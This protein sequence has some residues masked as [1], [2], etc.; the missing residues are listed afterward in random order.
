MD[1][2]FFER[3]DNISVYQLEMAKAKIKESSF[4]LTIKNMSAAS[5]FL[6]KGEMIGMQL[7]AT[8]NGYDFYAFGNTGAVTKDDIDRIFEPDLKVGKDK[9][10]FRNIFGCNGER[11]IYSAVIKVEDPRKRLECS[12]VRLFEKLMKSAVSK[13]VIIRFAFFGLGNNRTSRMKVL[14]SLHD[15]LSLSGKA[16]FG[17]S[18]NNLCLKEVNPDKD[19]LCDFDS[20]ETKV[21]IGECFKQFQN[22]CNSC[23]IEDE[24]LSKMPEIVDDE[25]IDTVY[26]EPLDVVDDSLFD[27]DEDWED[28]CGYDPFDDSYTEE[29]EIMSSPIK[30]S[31]YD[32]PLDE[33]GLTVRTYNCLLRAGYTKIGDIA[34]MSDKDLMKIRNLG[35]TGLTNIQTQMKNFYQNRYEEARKGSQKDYFAELNSLI[36]LSDVKKQVDK[37]TAFARMIK[38][39]RDLNLSNKVPISL[40]MDFAGNP[41]TAKTTVA[42]I[43]AGILYELGLLA[44]DEIVEVG[45]SS[46]VAKYVGQTADKVKSIFEHADGKLLFIDEAY[47]LLD[48]RENDFGDEAI[49]T[50]V[51]EMENRRSR[52]VVVFAGYPDKMKDFFDRNP[53]MRSRVPFHLEFADYDAEE[54]YRI[55]VKEAS[56]RGFTISENAKDGI[57]KICRK[58]IGNPNSGNGRFCR[59]LVESA[60]INYAYRVYGSKNIKERTFML[61]IEDFEENKLL[62]ETPKTTQFGFRGSSVEMPPA[63]HMAKA[64]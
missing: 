55:I 1:N 59:N 34:K 16:Y 42:R 3:F 13:R 48:C 41:G 62:T 31:D 50:I 14:I 49:S 53:G 26:G 15:E 38:D 4:Y 32:L 64:S 2:I 28:F 56:S 46:L 60:I 23:L 9:K 18:F 24:G 17:M 25:P 29:D 35:K 27:I 43:L 12:D 5:V 52:T 40:N 57:V 39:I 19:S 58:T 30:R 6:Q 47:S 61:E 37:I 45:R 63:Q 11:K 20:S 22:A 51:Q 8:D 7:Q 44:S 36:G 54:M 10:H 33:L 21:M